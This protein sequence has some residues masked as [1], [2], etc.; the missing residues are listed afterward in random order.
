MKIQVLKGSY[1]VSY[2]RSITQLTTKFQTIILNYSQ[3]DKKLL[4][5]FLF[6]VYKKGHIKSI[7]NI[8]IYSATCMYTITALDNL[9]RKF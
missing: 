6:R 3:N 1:P 8:F 2:R 4:P 9:K 5:N 7:Q